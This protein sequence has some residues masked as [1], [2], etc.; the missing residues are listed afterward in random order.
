VQSVLER[1]RQAYSTLNASAL[2]AV[3]PTVNASALA[4]AFN[5][6]EAQRFD[7]DNCQ[8]EISGPLARA[9]CTGTANF[10][11]KVGSKA[12]RVESRRWTFQLSQA[13]GSWIIDRV[14]SR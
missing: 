11:T 2:P 5:Q 6:L 8:I 10:I 7:F 13:K 9:I 1:Y 14:E 3:W 12:P 4:R